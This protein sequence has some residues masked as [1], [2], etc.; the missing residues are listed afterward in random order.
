MLPTRSIFGDDR[1]DEDG[2][3]VVQDLNGLAVFVGTPRDGTT[4]LHQLESPAEVAQV[5]RMLLA[6]WRRKL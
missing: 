2:F 5:L 4:A 3:K 1:T 6:L